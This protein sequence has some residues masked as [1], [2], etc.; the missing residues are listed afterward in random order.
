[1]HQF[2]GMSISFIVTYL[3]IFSIYFV[4]FN[5]KLGLSFVKWDRTSLWDLLANT[6]YLSCC[7]ILSSSWNWFQSKAR[8]TY[9]LTFLFIEKIFI[10]KRKSRSC[11]HEGSTRVKHSD[12]CTKFLKKSIICMITGECHSKITRKS[13]KSSNGSC[14]V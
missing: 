3:I 6:M 11:R 14:L 5:R 2:S 13:T 12:Q 9:Q 7:C 1:M 4:V 8:G 10:W